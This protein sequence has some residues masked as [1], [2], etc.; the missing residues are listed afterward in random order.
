M[1]YRSTLP[2]L[3][4]SGLAAA[5][6]LAGFLT[7][8]AA[9][10]TS[11]R[12]PR[13]AAAPAASAQ[14][15]ARTPAPLGRNTGGSEQPAVQP[16][17]TDHS[18]LRPQS[19]SKAQ[20]AAHAGVH[21]RLT[22]RAAAASCT[23]ADFGGRTGAALVSFVEASS[24]DCINTLFGLTGTDAGNVFD[25]SQMLTVADAFTAAAPAYPG[26]DS[27][28][29]WQLVLFLRAGYYV[30]FNNSAAVGSYDAS[31]TAATQAGMDAFF[32]DPHSADVTAAN[33]GVLGD[34]ITLTD[35][36]DDQAHY[37]DVYKRILTAFDSSSYDATGTMTPAVNN[38]FTPLWRGNWNPDFV[39]A[40][41]ADPSVID[42]LD[43]FALN[44]TALLGTG[45]SYVDANAGNDLARFTG[46]TALQ[47]KV[48][49]LVKGVLNATAMT[50]PT[51]PLWVAVA[52]QANYYDAA[53]CGYYGVC[54]L[55]AQLTAAVLPITHACD[56]THTIQA[57]SLSAADLAAACTSVLNEDAFFHNVVKDNGPIPGQY[58]ST[59]KLVVF[60]SR[61]DYQTYA[62]AIFDVDTDNGGI[63]L[64]GDPTD[65]A[66]QPM[67]I[68][69]IKSPDDGFVAGIWNLNHEYTHILD[70]RYDM[71]GDFAQQVTVP[72]IWWIEG[73]AEYDSYSYRGIT[74]DEAVTEAAKHTYALSTLF[75][76]T[77][78]NS[79]VTRTYPW[80]YLAVR[81]MLERHPQ[82]VYSMLGHFRTGD[83]AG[84]YAVY[85]GIGTGYDADFDSWLTAC[86]AGACQQ[87][88]TPP[89]CTAA[90]TRVMGQ[91]CS[92]SNQ[93]ATAGNLDYFYLYLPAGTTNL[94]ITTSGGTGNP[95]LYYSATGWATPSHHSS[96]STKAGTVQTITVT[97]K[98]AGYRYL[99]L[100][101][102]TAFSGVT[103]TTQY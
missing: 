71:K 44:H 25:E 31:L 49:P 28:G 97:N 96:A 69:Y 100:Y 10:A 57:Q 50:G 36:A 43:A 47:P 20:T 59:V 67:S 26:D 2:G 48:R 62:G 23:P 22:A 4:A 1:R 98:T 65:P 46:Q 42:T 58:E 63:T 90:D 87:P 84:G 101:A 88:V 24:T 45:D 66:N 32:A 55:P 72:D 68:M 103:V 80:G 35:S 95:Y 34:V 61:N 91:N 60:A 76:S 77:Y 56:S 82:D 81:Y 99:S 64:T 37:L 8:P 5:V 40:V 9:A 85:N 7:P 29:V 15:L 74:D 14:R 102:H 18:H 12:T 92:R 38:V 21:A 11:A 3:V 17:R 75:Q 53:N 16:G 70:A 27:T 13:T 39:S 33:G 6:A 86:A 41:T 54:N 79:D 19:P 52:S 94:T 51:A 30:Q 93:S 89:Q 73:V 78:E 83:Y